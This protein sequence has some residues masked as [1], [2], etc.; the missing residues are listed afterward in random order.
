M[1]KAKGTSSKGGAEPESTW[2]HADRSEVELGERIG[3]GGVGVIYHGYFRGEPVAL[4]TLFDTRVSEDLKQEYL[5]EL[6]VMSKVKHSNIVNFLGA[7]M[8]PPD[9]FFVMELCD[10]SL[11][12]MLHKDKVSLTERDCV[13]MAVSHHFLSKF[14]L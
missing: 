12:D 4:K 6:L 2:Y 9:L 11:F 1:E 14:N 10:C 8:T 5:D 13:Q 7:C 3:G